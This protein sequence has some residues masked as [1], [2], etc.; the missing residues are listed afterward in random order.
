MN[1]IVNGLICLDYAFLLLQSQIALVV[2][3]KNCLYRTE[4]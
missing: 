4:M 2:V 1:K 3:I